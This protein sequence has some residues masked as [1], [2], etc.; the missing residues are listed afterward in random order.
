MEKTR[1]EYGVPAERVGRD[2]LKQAAAAYASANRL[3][4][5]LSME[6]LRDHASR[7][8]DE[9]SLIDYAMVLLNNE[10]WRDTVASIPYSR[11]LLLLPQCLRNS[12]DCPATLD[13]FGLLCEECGR[14][15]IGE[16]QVLAEDL[17]YVVLVAEGSTVVSRL[18][19][20]GKVDA[21]V[22][23]SCLNALEK[24]F[25]HMADGAIP[26][27][28]VPLTV[29]GCV[30]TKMDTDRVREAIRLKSSRPWQ[31]QVDTRA[32]REIVDGWF[33]N[34]FDCKTETE[35]IAYDW[36]L[37]DGK[38]WRPFL[39]A[40]TY[41]ALND[42]ATELPEDIRRLA[43]AVECFHKASL[44]HDDIED[45]DDLR[46]GQPTLHKQF[47]VPVAI[48]VG[49][50]LVGEGY[51][52]IASVETG[53]AHLLRIAAENHRTLCIG[54]GEELGGTSGNRSFDTDQILE[55]FRQKTA[56]AFGVALQLGAVAAG[57]DDELLDS[58]RDF[59][60]SLGIAYQIRDDLEEYQSG[61]SCDLRASILLALANDQKPL[62]R[63][64]A[65][66]QNLGH[67]FDELMVVEKASQLLEH[68]RNEALRAL[69]PLRNALLKTLL[70]RLAVKMLNST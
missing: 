41:S 60:E 56:P 6:E 66:T 27:L 61:D 2:E 3:M 50:L 17:G 25:P 19:E 29:D 14:C 20:G 1:P 30:G 65:D 22:G 38:R 53:T 43:V 40:C 52:W 26:G 62:E 33:S 69:N 32:I 34:A 11:R 64:T 37:K 54:Q 12:T 31:N 23:V 18:L 51:R 35:R 47:G 48:N 58:L 55:I 39:L 70:R 16:L 63:L 49:D 13:E 44:A 7:I 36:L 57:A 21:V 10:V 42:A 4:P 28:A 59:S 8:T 9:A 15:D 67:I 24:S 68:Y 5:P 46:Y 45:D